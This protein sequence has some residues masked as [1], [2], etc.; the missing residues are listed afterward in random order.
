MNFLETLQNK[1]EKNHEVTIV[2]TNSYHKE[3]NKKSPYKF[4][5]EIAFKTEPYN[6][7]FFSKWT[8]H[9]GCIVNETLKEFYDNKI[10]TLCCSQCDDIITFD[11]VYFN[12]NKENK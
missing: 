9:Y 6:G 7:T 8:S 1:L 10:Y 5:Y 3:C 4:I 2:P 12:R 11:V